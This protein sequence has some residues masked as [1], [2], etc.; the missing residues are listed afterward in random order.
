MVFA[1]PTS[2]TSSH[3][4]FPLFPHPPQIQ[5]AVF[6]LNNVTYAMSTAGSSP[7]L[8]PHAATWL[9]SHAGAVR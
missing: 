6:V 1:L 2:P 5:A 7:A 9:A 8:A 3:P 4:C